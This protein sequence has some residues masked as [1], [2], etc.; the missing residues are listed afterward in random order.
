[1]KAI[2]FISLTVVSLSA[3]SQQQVNVF[4]QNNINMPAQIIQTSNYLNNDNTANNPIEQQQINLIDNTIGNI[5]DSQQISNSFKQIND[6]ISSNEKGYDNSFNFS[7]RSSRVSANKKI[8][9]HTLQKKIIKF[10]RN[11]Q[12]KMTLHKKSKHLV[13]VC[14]NWSK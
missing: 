1:M 14:F 6:V 13:D 7:L 2:Y 5:D 10:S 4:V 3:F 9:K 11:V 12:G 8:H